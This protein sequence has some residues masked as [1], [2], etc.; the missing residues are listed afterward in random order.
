MSFSILISQLYTSFLLILYNNIYMNA[1]YKMHKIN[2][3]YY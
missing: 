3:F 2:I 1:I